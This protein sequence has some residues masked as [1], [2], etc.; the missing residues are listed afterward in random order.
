VSGKQTETGPGS[1]SVIEVFS[2][3]F[4]S[5]LLIYCGQELLVTRLD[6]IDNE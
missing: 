6:I 1:G 2:S 4:D 5:C 3:I